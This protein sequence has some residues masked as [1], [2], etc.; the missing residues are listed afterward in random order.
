MIEKAFIITQRQEGFTVERTGDFIFQLWAH[1]TLKEALEC[2]EKLYN[3][4]EPV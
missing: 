3:S 4:V 2:V 1:N